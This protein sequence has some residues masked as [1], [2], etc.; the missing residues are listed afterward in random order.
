[1]FE[2]WT[3]KGG[4]ADIV[5]EEAAFQ[6]FRKEPFWRHWAVLMGMSSSQRK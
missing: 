3:I 5:Q 1:M 6:R 4:G 2:R